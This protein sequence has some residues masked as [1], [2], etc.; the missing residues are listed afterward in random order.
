MVDNKLAKLRI[1]V[2]PEDGSGDREHTDELMRQLY[3]ELSELHI[4]HL[5]IKAKDAAP[6]GVKGMEGL[7][8]EILVAF[9]AH[10]V[11][12]VFTLIRRW[13]KRS[14]ERKVKVVSSISGKEVEVMISS[15]DLKNEDVD[16]I[17]QSLLSSF[18]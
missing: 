2:L 7:A 17:V 8:A 16:K 3:Q 6:E 14:P 10:Y 4:D 9:V 1:E 18:A 13:V 15:D 5:E 12:E 11:P